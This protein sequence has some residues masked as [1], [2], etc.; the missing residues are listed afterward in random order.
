MVTFRCHAD[1]SSL[2]VGGTL[3]QLSQDGHLLVLKTAR[4]YRRTLF[5]ERPRTF[6]VRVPFED[7]QMLPRE[8][9]AQNN[10]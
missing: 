4:Q 7:F 6:L 10:S 2:A 8:V 9:T 1:A 5:G 3:T